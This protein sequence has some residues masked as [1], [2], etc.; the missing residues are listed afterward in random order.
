MDSTYLAM[1]AVIVS[2]LGLIVQVKLCLEG[3]DHVEHVVLVVEESI[4]VVKEV[5][6]GLRAQTEVNR[7]RIQQLCQV[8]VVTRSLT[9]KL[10]GSGSREVDKCF[11]SGVNNLIQVSDTL[12]NL[13]WSQVSSVI[14]IKEC[15]LV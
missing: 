12:N 9:V 15:V 5:G 6:V 7:I 2:L 13:D 10:I 11:I 8:W 14:D 3:G 1:Q 4:C